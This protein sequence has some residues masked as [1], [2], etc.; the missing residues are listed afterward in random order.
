[1]VAQLHDGFYDLR[2]A[3]DQLVELQESRNA[4]PHLILNRVAS[5]E[6]EC[7]DITEIIRLGLIGSEAMRPKQAFDY[8]ETHIKGGFLMD[9]YQAAANALFAALHGPDDEPA[10]TPGEA[11][12]VDQNPMIHGA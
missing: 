7:Q 3:F 1:M 6:F 9:Y 5:H 10:P 8:V 11:N 12:P 2:L 4:G